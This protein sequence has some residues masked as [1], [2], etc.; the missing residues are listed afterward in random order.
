MSVT[1]CG[2]VPLRSEQRQTRSR[3]KAFDQTAVVDAQKQTVGVTSCFL[4][5]LLSPFSSFFVSFPLTPSLVLVVVA[6]ALVY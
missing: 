1:S 3:D 2:A 6:A 5:L 4:L